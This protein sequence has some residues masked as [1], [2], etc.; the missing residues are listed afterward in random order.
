MFAQTKQGLP[1]NLCVV[2]DAISKNLK[3]SQNTS[4]VKTLAPTRRP[5]IRLTYR[6]KKCQTSAKTN[7]MIRQVQLAFA[8]LACSGAKL[9]NILLH[10]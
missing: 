6:S 9:N 5:Q 10:P 4:Q 7:P 1:E 3:A 2:T 8:E